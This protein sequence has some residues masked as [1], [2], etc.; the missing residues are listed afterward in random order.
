MSTTLKITCNTYEEEDFYCKHCE[1][2]L[3]TKQDFKYNSK[4]GCCHECY[5]VF[6]ESQKERWLAGWRPDKKV[7]KQHQTKIKLLYT[8]KITDYL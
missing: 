3:C 8:K 4:F 1:Y 5:L 6:V 2:P 7:L